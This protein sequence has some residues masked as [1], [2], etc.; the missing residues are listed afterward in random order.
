MLVQYFETV[1]KK[2]KKERKTFYRIKF[3]TDTKTSERRVLKSLLLHIRHLQKDE[4]KKFKKCQNDVEGRDLFQ[5]DPYSEA[6]VDHSVGVGS[7]HG[8]FLP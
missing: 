5:S 3:V 1:R 4:E 8:W 6:V 7:K 2:I